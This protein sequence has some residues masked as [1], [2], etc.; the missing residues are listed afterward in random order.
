MIHGMDLR[1]FGLFSDLSEEN[2][3]FLRIPAHHAGVK[4][5]HEGLESFDVLQVIP[6]ARFFLSAPPSVRGCNE[7]AEWRQSNV[8]RITDQSLVFCPRADWHGQLLVNDLGEACILDPLLQLRP[9][10]RFHSILRTALD[11]QI[12]RFEH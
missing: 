2:V 5:H 11:E 7:D 9:G 12:G 10:T 4:C 1:I 3:D 6:R 8:E